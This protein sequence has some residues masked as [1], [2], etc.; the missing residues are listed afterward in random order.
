MAE[1][2]HDYTNIELDNSL[3]DQIEQRKK[4]FYMKYE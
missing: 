4:E 1:E 3:Q 2:P